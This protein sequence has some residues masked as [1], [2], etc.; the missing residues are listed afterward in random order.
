MGIDFPVRPLDVW[1]CTGCGQRLEFDR[2]CH[3]P[4]DQL[5]ACRGLCEWELLERPT[6]TVDTPPL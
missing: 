6:T 4:Q 1:F 5:N 3:V 2:R